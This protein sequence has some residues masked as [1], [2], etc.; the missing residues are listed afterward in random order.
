MGMVLVVLGIVAMA[1]IG[2][3]PIFRSD[4]MSLTYDMMAEDPDS[5]DAL[6]VPNSHVLGHA[7]WAMVGAGLTML[8]GLILILEGKRVINLRRLLPWHAEARATAL[9]SLAAMLGSIGLFAGASLLGLTESM[10]SS[11]GGGV[12]VVI[13][14]SSPAAIVVVIA[15]GLATFGMLGMAYYNGV[16]SV[17]RG[18]GEPGNRRMVRYA[19]FL[20]FLSLAVAFILR[21]G[22]IMTAVIEYPFG[23]D[24]SID[25]HWYYTMSRIDHQATLGAGEEAKGTLSWQLTIVS[26]LLF[27][28]FLV[29]MSGIIGC[30][31]RSLGG[32]GLRVRRATALPAV[33]VLLLCIALLMFAWASTTAPEAALESLTQEG[34][35]AEDIKVTI[36]WGLLVGVVLT[37]GALA[38]TLAYLRGLGMEYAKEALAFWKRPE[39]SQEALEEEGIPQPSV[40][41]ALAEE[42]RARGDLPPPE[43][44]LEV[45][46]PPLRERILLKDAR[47]NQI[48]IAV[49]LIV[50][51]LLLAVLLPGDGGD[52][53][54]NGGSEKVVIEELPPFDWSSTYNVYLTEGSGYDNR[55]FDD[56]ET[57]PTTLYFIDSVHVS[58]T[59]VDEPP[60]G[61]L[62]TNTPDEF[63]VSVNDGLGLDNPQNSGENPQGGQGSLAVTWST[64]GPWVAYGPSDLVDWGDQDVIVM[65]DLVSVDYYV[66]MQRAGD[67]VTRLGRTQTDQGNDCTITVTVSG[68]VYNA[69]TNGQ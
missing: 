65:F 26:A 63:Q 54:G 40:D 38:S 48:I 69:E 25:I 44:E 27:L 24:L 49:V 47:R 6:G 36:G 60:A 46:T 32:S 7:K 53:N 12:T 37:I 55:A 31:A 3:M 56:L 39:L 10:P 62:W 16:L 9:F 45:P 50:L 33:S 43:P 14:A 30:S 29:A 5:T 51:I 28:S 64:G 66:D 68:H 35:D 20:A 13:P 59:W 19:M 52:G 34:L 67:Q 42:A 11:S 1:A 2:F 18:G 61:I 15:M 57:G 8:M 21:V 4:E 17:Y 58:V 23:P 22:I 41:Q